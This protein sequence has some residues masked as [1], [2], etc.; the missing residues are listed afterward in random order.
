MST[1]LTLGPWESCGNLIRTKREAD[2]SGGFL[3]AEVPANT[4]DTTEK[5]MVMAAAP[6][7]LAVAR[8]V[9]R[10]LYAQ[11]WNGNGFDPESRLLAASRAAIAKATGAQ[12]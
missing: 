7:L 6:E 11:G 9:E 10:L 8:E 5:A 3:I 4:G 12:S 2:G 1:A